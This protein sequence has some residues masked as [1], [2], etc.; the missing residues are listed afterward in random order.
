MYPFGRFRTGDDM[1]IYQINNI[2]YYLSKTFHGRNAELKDTIFYE[3]FKIDN[4]NST[5]NFQMIAEFT[6]TDEDYENPKTFKSNLL[7]K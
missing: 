2:N 1:D 7:Q 6:Y 5:N 3:L 4:I